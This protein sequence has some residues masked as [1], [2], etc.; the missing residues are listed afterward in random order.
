M[1]KYR[2]FL[3]KQLLPFAKSTGRTRLQQ[4]DVEALREFRASWKF[5]ASTQQ[6]KLETFWIE[7]NPAPAVKLPKVHHVPT[8]PLQVKKAHFHRLR[9]PFAIGLFENPRQA[10]SCGRTAR[11]SIRLPCTIGRTSRAS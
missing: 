10:R 3:E 11:T 7:S 2:H 5:K 8:L 6:K 1:R 4:L 9:D